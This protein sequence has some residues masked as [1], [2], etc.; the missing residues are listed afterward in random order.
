MISNQGQQQHQQQSSMQS[1]VPLTLGSRAANIK[2][3]TVSTSNASN[4]DHRNLSSN[5]AT[6]I[7]PITKIISQTTHQNIVTTQC[8]AFVQVFLFLFV[9]HVFF[10]FYLFLLI[11]AQNPPS[12]S[13]L[14]YEQPSLH[15]N[16]SNADKGMSSSTIESYG[17]S[18]NFRYSDKM[19]HSIIQNSLQNNS[20]NSGTSTI[21]FSPSVVESQIATATSAGQQQLIGSIVQSPSIDPSVASHMIVQPVQPAS[22][23][24]NLPSGSNTVLRKLSET[25]PTKTVKKQAKTKGFQNEPTMSQAKVTQQQQQQQ[26][27]QPLSAAVAQLTQNIKPL[28]VRQQQQQHS[29]ASSPKTNFS[30]RESS[31]HDDAF[32]DGSTTVSVPG[33]PR[34]DDDDLDEEILKNDLAAAKVVEDFKFFVKSPAKAAASLKREAPD[35]RDNQQPTPRKKIKK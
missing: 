34:S 19:I 3:I 15:S 8:E 14:Y 9:Q 10:N 16:S 26:R 21:R 13:T 25:T 2:T 12:T 27:L 35:A 24:G 1:V 28:E 31:P 29:T 11:L 4:I 6:T 5:Q 22:P 23:R 7:M 17:S 30:E 33:S 32:S 20:S 18:A